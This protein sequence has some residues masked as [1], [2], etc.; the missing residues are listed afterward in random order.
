MNICVERKY[1]S[2]VKNCT[3]ISCKSF[4]F[5]QALDKEEIPLNKATAVIILIKLWLFEAEPDYIVNLGVRCDGKLF[6][7]KYLF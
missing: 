4:L 6:N 1:V 3:I 7:F 2:L 5:Q